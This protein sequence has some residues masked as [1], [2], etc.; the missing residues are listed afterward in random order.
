MQTADFLLFQ[1]IVDIFFIIDIVV[2]F[3]TTFTDNDGREVTDAISIAKGYFR[4][5]F[6]IDLVAGIPLD[7]IM[8]K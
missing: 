2:C 3:R 8:P 6:I 7:F 5:T 4:G 1:V